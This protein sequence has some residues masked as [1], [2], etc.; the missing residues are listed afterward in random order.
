MSRFFIHHPIFAWVLAIVTMLFGVLAI[1]TL[2]ISQYPEVA[3]P[4]IRIHSQ[5]TGASPST[6]DQTVTQVIEQNMTGI[7]NLI[8]MQSRSDSSGMSTITLTFEVGTDPDVA[9]MQVQNK[10]QQVQS[11]LPSAVQSN[12]V[13]VSKGNDNMFMVITLYSP[14]DSLHQIDLADYI[15]TNI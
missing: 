10:V 1:F 13:E 6:V 7:D 5:Y 3:S 4:S 8:Y 2:P 14:D 11:Q 12:G 15:S 9:H